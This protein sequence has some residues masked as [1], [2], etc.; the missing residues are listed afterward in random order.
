MILAFI[1]LLGVLRKGEVAKEYKRTYE[2]ELAYVEQWRKEHPGEFGPMIRGPLEESDTNIP[3][4]L[5]SA[6]ATPW[7]KWILVIGIAFVVILVAGIGVVLAC[8]KK[9]RHTGEEAA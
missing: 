6:S 5:S 1:G 3:L 7:S 9:Q 4:P 2:E 8:R